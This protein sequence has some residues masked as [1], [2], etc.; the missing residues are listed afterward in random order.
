MYQA[1]LDSS[2]LVLNK[3][4][5]ALQVICVKRAISLL[6]RKLAEVISLEEGSYFTYDFDS[7][8]QVSEFRS[9]FPQM[10]ND[11][12]R[13]VNFWIAVPRIVR[14]ITYDRFPKTVVKLNRKNLFARDNNICQ[15]CGKKFPT[16]EL[17][18]DH[19]IPKTLGGLTT[20]DN[21]VCSCIR[22]NSRKGGRTPVQTKMKLL[23][24]PKMPNRNP[25]MDLQVNNHIYSS[26]KK[27][28]DYAYWFVE[29]K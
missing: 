10:S 19:V 5:M 15:Y 20:W 11:W 26:W 6:Y 7:W 27:F 23:N 25:A 18:L 2:V 21:L 1:S 22:C 4:Y 29:L 14:L 24:T 3:H 13:T 17:S 16:A 8:Q 12:I 9:K 28:L